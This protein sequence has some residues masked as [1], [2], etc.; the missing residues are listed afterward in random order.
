MYLKNRGFKMAHECPECT[1]VASK[2]DIYIAPAVFKEIKRKPI[3]LGFFTLSGWNGHSGFYAFECRACN[4]IVVDY[5]HSYSVNGLLFMVCQDCP[6]G[7]ETLAGLRTTLELK[8]KKIYEREG[9]AFKSKR[10]IKKELAEEIK[11][12]GLKLLSEHYPQTVLAKEDNPL[13]QP[14]D[15]KPMPLI[16]PIAVLIASVILLVLIFGKPLF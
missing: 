2:D 13:A 6:W 8:D 14:P 1:F 10:T 12:M 15:H 16:I 4:N 7:A 11:K 9:I 3:F 5:P